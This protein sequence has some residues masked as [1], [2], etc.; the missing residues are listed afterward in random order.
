M[1]LNLIGV[2]CLFCKKLISLPQKLGDKP[3]CSRYKIIP[4]II[5]YD[6]KNCIHYTEDAELKGQYYLDD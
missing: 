3:S 1:T 4:D 5:F 2:Q 6:G